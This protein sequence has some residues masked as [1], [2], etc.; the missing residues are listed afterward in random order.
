MKFISL[1]FAT[2]LSIS[3]Y[4]TQA[5]AAAAGAANDVDAV[6]HISIEAHHKKDGTVEFKQSAKHFGNKKEEADIV[7]LGV[8]SSL[9]D[10]GSKVVDKGKE[11]AG[12]A[13]DVAKSAGS[14]VLDAGKQVA[15]TALQG[16]VNFV[17]D[18]ANIIKIAKGGIEAGTAYATGGT[19]GLT[20]HVAGKITGAG[21]KP[22]AS[23]DNDE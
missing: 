17:T 14:A 22:V 16:T 13:V 3:L 8:F 21:K 11:L 18:P 9:K 6:T 7:S 2:I 19:K 15:S 1:T 12:K 5:A 20:D 4:T 23:N 10:L